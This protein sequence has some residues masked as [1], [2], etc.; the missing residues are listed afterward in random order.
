M[1]Q[2]FELFELFD[3]KKVE[4]IMNIQLFFFCVI[5]ILISTF[6]LAE[7]IIKLI[8]S[9]F[10]CTDIDNKKLKKGESTRQW[11]ILSTIIL[12]V[13]IW[14]IMT[15]H[16]ISNQCNKI[17]DYD[18]IESFV[19][20]VL[21]CSY[22]IFDLIYHEMSRLNYF[23]H[24][25]SLIPVLMIFLTKYQTGSYYA[26]SALLTE[27]STVPMGMIYIVPKRYQSICKIIFAVTFFFARPMFLTYIVAITYKCMKNEL[28]YLI[29]ILFLVLL[30]CLNLYWFVGIYNKYCDYYNE[31]KKK[32]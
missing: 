15:H 4:N 17:Y 6:A 14:Y 20:L 24:A 23:H 28:T 31:K 32:M 18:V 13:L 1:N 16:Q 19:P 5:L 27:L 30:Y 12:M 8:L 21:F 2:M 9:L 22:I 10:H 25:I 26:V 29:C 11:N 7:N 3:I